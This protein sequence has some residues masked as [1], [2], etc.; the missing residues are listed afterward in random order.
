M[1]L[2][3]EALQNQSFLS[4]AVLFQDGNNS[5]VQRRNPGRLF[6]QSRD[7]LSIKVHPL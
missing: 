3:T 1:L 2:M 5:R 6:E 7:V 4:V